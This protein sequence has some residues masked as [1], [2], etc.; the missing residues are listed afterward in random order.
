MKR[1]QRK[2]AL[3]HRNQLTQTEVHYKSALICKHLKPYLHGNVGVYQSYGK[4]VDLTSLSLTSFYLPKVKEEYGMDFVK[5]DKNTTYHKDR[6]GILEPDDHQVINPLALDVIVVP[7]V[8]FDENRHR[9]GH[10]CGYYDRYLIHTK[11]LKIGVAY[12]CQKV[13]FIQ[14]DVFDV[15]LDMIITEDHIYK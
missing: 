5:C 3:Y 7:L 11:A 4:E 9:I 2:Q 12:E 8:A 14:S 1:F 10:G 6:Y 15:C 13:D